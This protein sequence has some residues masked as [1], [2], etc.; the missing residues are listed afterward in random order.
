MAESRVTDRVVALVDRV[1]EAHQGSPLEADA[2]KIKKR[3]NGPLRVAIAGRVKAGKSTLLNALVGQ[4]LA[5]TDT[6]DC[7][8]VVT[9]Y[10]HGLTYRV[11]LEPEGGDA[12]EAAF[13]RETGALDIDLDGL[14]PAQLRR[15][16][17]AWP[18]P[19]LKAVTL[20][21]TPGLD[22]V[23]SDRSARTVRLLAD[24]DAPTEADAVIYLM[25]HMHAEDARFLEAFHDSEVGHACP[26]NAVGVLSRADEIGVGRVDAMD[27]AARIAQRYASDT[28]VRRLC[29]TVVP[30]AGLL[31]Q[32]AA[33]LAED[34]YR[35]LA[36]L[37]A[38]QPEQTESLL[39]TADRFLSEDPRVELPEV[40]RTHLLERL[41]L[42]G[43]RVSIEAVRE[44]R[45]ASSGEL[46]A[47]LRE[48]SGVDGLRELLAT[49]FTE[50]A[51]IL[52]ARSAIDAL[53]ALIERSEHPDA[54]VLESELEALVAS[55]HELAE[56][57]LLNGLR[58]GAVDL[59]DDA[60]T[61]ERLLG[62][63][64]MDSHVR[65]GMPAGAT[66]EDLRAMIAAEHGRWQAR[67]ESPFA[68]PTVADAARV[69]V[70]SCEGMLAEA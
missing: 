44:G 20:I 59:G 66:P 56:V 48:V 8:A 3:L 4:E 55:A 11:T 23:D 39:L 27:S 41:G 63:D 70:R 26:V 45:A 42:F 61:A 53:G 37:A 30:V 29:Q 31:A 33:T 57:R 7:T 14:A 19:V 49:R 6:R 65:L 15:I 58:A 69:L 10:E 34:E 12:R 52:K 2:L 5:P 67:A 25:R 38:M 22:S 54:A 68:T 13:S 32:A 40:V 62:A 60:E 50:R 51:G 21:D 43:V 24:D 64:G 1:V 17:V 18:S 35:A 9:W 28:R 47:V 16:V 46:A 36:M